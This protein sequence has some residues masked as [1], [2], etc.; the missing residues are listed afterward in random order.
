MIRFD[1]ASHRVWIA[2]RRI[3][4]GMVGLILFGVSIALMVDDAHDF[5]WIG[6]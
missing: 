4:H 1:R 6:D 3:H 2:R 5:P